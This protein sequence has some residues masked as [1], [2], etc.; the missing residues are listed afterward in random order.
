MTEQ[1]KK[2]FG[3]IDAYQSKS[4]SQLPAEFAAAMKQV[5]DAVESWCTDLKIAH[6]DNIHGVD[7][8]VANESYSVDELPLAVG[9]EQIH[10]LCVAAKV[11][12]EHMT[13]AMKRVA[14]LLVACVGKKQGEAFTNYRITNK[15]GIT[16]TS[17]ESLYPAK[18]VQELGQGK[19]LESFGIQIDRVTP[20]LKTVL[21]IGLM[22]FTEN[23][24]PRFVPIHT[25]NQGNVTFVLESL[26][27]FDMASDDA[28]KPVRLIE[29][30]R[31]P[32]MVNVRAIR[33]RPLKAN[34]AAGEFLV[35]DD[36]YK[37][38]KKLNLF[39]L[40]L[41][42]KKPGYEKYSHTD[43]V[44]EGALI[45]GV[46]V[47]I[48]TTS[49]LGEGTVG[50][51]YAMLKVP[52]GRGR[53]TQITDD[54]RS[55]DRR[56]A[57]ERFSYRIDKRQPAFTGVSSLVSTEGVLNGLVD[58]LQLSVDFNLHFHIDRKVALGDASGTLWLRLLNSTGA[59]LTAAQKEWLAGTSVEAVGFTMDARYNED[60]KR[61]SSVRAELNTRTM[62]FDIPTGRNFIIDTAIGQ[63]G[64]QAGAAK[65]A[66]LEH[67]GR[68][69][70]NLDITNE[71]M[72]AVHDQ[73][74]AFNNDREGQM[75]L[76]ATYAAGNCVNPYV[77]MNTLDMSG[78]YGIRAGDMSGDIKQYVKQYFNRI[79]SGILAKSLYR[80]QLAGGAKVVFR[81]I[82][83][84]EI[85]GNLF[86][87]KHFHANLD[88]DEA[89]TGGV[90]HVVV[91]DN[92]VRLEI[93]T[94]NFRQMESKIILVPFIASAPT[95]V[96]NFGQD[97]D[98]GTLVGTFP[99]GSEGGAAFNR[100]F[101]V[102]RELLIPTNVIGAVIDVVG[103]SA[104]N[105]TGAGSLTVN[106]TEEAGA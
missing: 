67:L 22:S 4:A 35:A 61:K 2:F 11:P 59:E 42:E 30:F 97:W 8:L 12:E 34:D 80:E 33:I 38:N 53:L 62:N 21:S 93:I 76:A 95:S 66:Q 57:L 75:Q 25:T 39:A 63:E 69:A 50:S 100:M 92:G 15:T 3:D 31:D 90:E 28:R 27:I 83:S 18:I 49:Q 73:N 65:L 20:D 58:G 70:N 77:Y 5:G 106:G 84:P 1:I 23:L 51:F 41:N 54:L 17:L 86:M 68:D 36:I 7:T 6:V 78:L 9:A 47:K 56:L 88:N 105:M 45:D 96:F 71:V 37:F 10:N 87:M 19:S 13:A 102:T 44:E 104:V 89:G 14:A 55:T 26:D 74:V 16:K 24:T 40:A 48:T 85:L 81:V 46:L 101:S 60:N 82:T 64:A 98:Q 43:L 52:S 72:R 29:L 91:L 94:T 32:K 99:V 79:T 103:T